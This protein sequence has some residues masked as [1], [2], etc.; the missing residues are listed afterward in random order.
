MNIFDVNSQEHLI[1][2]MIKTVSN[3]KDFVQY[4]DLDIYKPL[5][6]ARKHIKLYKKLRR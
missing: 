1:N 5:N 3:Q 2:K 6:I 4:P